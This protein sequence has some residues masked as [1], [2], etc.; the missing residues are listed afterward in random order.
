VKDKGLFYKKPGPVGNHD[1][2]FGPRALAE[3]VPKPRLCPDSYPSGL[4]EEELTL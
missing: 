4:V 3:V 1:G 2:F